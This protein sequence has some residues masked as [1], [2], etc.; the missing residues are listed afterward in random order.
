MFRGGQLV[1]DQMPGRRGREAW[2]RSGRSSIVELANFSV[3]IAA[4][5]IF[6]YHRRAYNW[7]LVTIGEVHRP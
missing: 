1:L 5:E 7:Y 6:G 4:K 2:R 3:T